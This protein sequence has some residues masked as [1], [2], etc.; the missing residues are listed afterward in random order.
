MQ[1]VWRCFMAYIYIRI[2]FAPLSK[3][4]AKRNSSLA[5]WGQCHKS[6]L[7]PRAQ[8]MYFLHQTSLNVY[9]HTLLNKVTMLRTACKWRRWGEIAVHAFIAA[10]LWWNSLPELCS[11]RKCATRLHLHNTY[12]YYYTRTRWGSPGQALLT[13]L[14]FTQSFMLT[15]TCFGATQRRKFAKSRG[16]ENEGRRLFAHKVLRY[17]ALETSQLFLNATVL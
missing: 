13:V 17:G 5:T 4:G 14:F 16:S 9:K 8:Q 15:L 12:Y 1:I 6:R 10:T 3:H 11:A 7:R 2:A